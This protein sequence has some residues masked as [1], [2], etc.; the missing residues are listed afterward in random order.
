VS[1]F[2]FC[3]LRPRGRRRCL[4]IFVFNP[5]QRWKHFSPST[6]TVSILAITS[7]A[8]FFLTGFLDPNDWCTE[9]QYFPC[10]TLHLVMETCMY[11]CMYVCKMQAVLTA[12]DG[13]ERRTHDRG[14]NDSL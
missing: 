2:L 9:V 3:F 13:K 11:A 8:L 10:K 4:Y 1:D 5:Y 12:G 7:L 6:H 14:K